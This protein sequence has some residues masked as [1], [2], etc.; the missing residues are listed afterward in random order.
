VLNDPPSSSSVYIETAFDFNSAHMT[1]GGELPSGVSVIDHSTVTLSQRTFTVHSTIYGTERGPVRRTPMTINLVIRTVLLPGDWRL[2]QWAER[3]IR[4]RGMAGYLQL[5]A[6]S[7]S[8]EPPQL[9]NLSPG[10]WIHL[11]ADRMLEYNPNDI[12][13]EP[14]DADADCG[15]SCRP[16]T[17]KRP[18]DPEDP[19]DDP[20]AER[21]AKRGPCVPDLNYCP[22]PDLNNNPDVP[23]LN[24]PPEEQ[25]DA[26]EDIQKYGRPKVVFDTPRIP[27]LENPNLFHWFVPVIRGSSWGS[28]F[29]VAPKMEPPKKPKKRPVFCYETIWG[30]T[31]HDYP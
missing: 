10:I 20:G 22:V 16:D 12:T 9:P 31:V 13:C 21:G 5:G 1:P 7:S 8:R 27:E 26:G 30:G 24:D 29:T 11:L 14:R 2:D 4:D 3:G 25:C 23:D 17:P 19:E 6:G 15:P 28:W 18:R